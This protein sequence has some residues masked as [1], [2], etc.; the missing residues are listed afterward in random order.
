M[1]SGRWS[2]S[3]NGAMAPESDLSQLLE[4]MNPELHPGI[5][6]FCQLA[7]RHFSAGI[8]ARMQF[9]E[10]EATT[11][12]VT[13]EQAAAAGLHAV[14]PSAWI[15]LGVESDL[16]AVGFLAAVTERLAAA[17][18]ST[19]VVS[20]YHHDHLF[21]PF[22]LADKALEVLKALARDADGSV[23]LGSRWRDET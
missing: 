17:G 7:D 8:E 9:V 13:Q 12:V 16:A 20:A 5:F 21:V 15:T 3:D 1:L 10:D 2:C 4:R 22:D 23:R 18:I 11:V 6:V 19:N 14:F